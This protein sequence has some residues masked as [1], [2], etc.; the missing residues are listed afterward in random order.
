M[1]LTEHQIKQ[2][3]AILK[4]HDVSK[5]GLF[6]SYASGEATQGSDVDIL[7][8]FSGEK[9]LLDIVRL[10]HELEDTLSIDVDVVTYGALHP[11]IKDRVLESQRVLV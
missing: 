4:R 2:V 5:A 10:K 6:G 1:E 3:V 8:E 9:T 11:L 7:V